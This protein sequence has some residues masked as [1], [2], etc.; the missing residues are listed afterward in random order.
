M[1]VLKKEDRSYDSLLKKLLST[2]LI[3]NLC[4]FPIVQVSASA[5][6]S[7]VEV[8]QVSEFDMYYDLKM[9]ND[10]ELIQL[11]FSELEILQL[12]EFDLFD[13]MEERSM[14]DDETLHL[15][16]YSEN[17]IIELREYVASGGRL[18]KVISG[19]TLSLSLSF[20]GQ[21][22]KRSATGIFT[23]K[24]SRVPFF[25]MIDS[26]GVAWQKDAGSGFFNYKNDGYNKVTYTYTK[27]NPNAYGNATE[28]GTSNW[29]VVTNT[30][31]DAK[32]PISIGK[33][34]FAFSGEG[35]FRLESTSGD[36][37]E[38]YIDAGYG[39]SIISFEPGISISPGG[40]KAGVSFK[41]GADER[42]IKR[43]YNGSFSVVH[44]YD[45]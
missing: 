31:I 7:D 14:L 28:K 22:A 40:V 42:H 24:W 17:D 11:G 1:V 3:F 20:T 25:T 33:D 39:H 6:T 8:Y 15:Y 16:G 19:S 9:K 23:W 41:G 5:L 12:R 13:A 36:I 44:N 27:I 10:S 35:R 37:T 29:R 38:F 18:R 26:I 21:V 2:F 4:T 43:V 34:Y 32:I 30:A 45:D